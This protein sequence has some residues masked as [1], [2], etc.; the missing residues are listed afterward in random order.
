[1]NTDIPRIPAALR[2]WRRH[3]ISAW[4]SGYHGGDGMSHREPISM[5]S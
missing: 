3:S 2:A 5:D 1:M 4:K